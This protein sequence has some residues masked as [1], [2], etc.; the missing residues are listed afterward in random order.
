MEMMTIKPRLNMDMMT[1]TQTGC[2]NDDY[3]V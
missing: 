2:V 3:K 1:K